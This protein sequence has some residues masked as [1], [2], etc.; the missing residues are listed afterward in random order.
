M[1]ER[2]GAGSRSPAAEEAKLSLASRFDIL[3]NA[4]RRYVLE[5]LREHDGPV[6][7]GDLSKYVAARE[8]G[9]DVSELCSQQRKRVYVTLYQCH[10]P[11][12]DE[13]G[14]VSFDTDGGIVL[15]EAAPQLYRYL[16][17]YT[18]PPDRWYRYYLCAVAGGAVSLGVSLLIGGAYGVSTRAVVG[19]LVTVLLACSLAHVLANVGPGR[20]RE[21]VA[22][23][24]LTT[25]RG[26]NER[27]LS[28][29]RAGRRDD[30]HR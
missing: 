21:R 2:R 24:P 17:P 9:T 23:S 16:P 30:V 11:R 27:S 20:S 8:I 19:A 29:D 3:K 1:P 15:D 25:A 6:A 13:T 14:V 28:P 4:R 18:L 12:L 22:L 26:L 7:I 10:L 5:C